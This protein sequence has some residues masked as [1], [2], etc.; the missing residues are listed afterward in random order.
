MSPTGQA[1]INRMAVAVSAEGRKSYQDRKQSRGWRK[2]DDQQKIG[3]QAADRAQDRD[4]DRE[5]Q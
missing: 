4:E 1:P 2:N 5:F 3:R